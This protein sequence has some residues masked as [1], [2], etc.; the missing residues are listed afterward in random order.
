MHNSSDDIRVFLVVPKIIVEPAFEVRLA[1][2]PDVSLWTGFLYGP[3]GT[4]VA[5]VFI[6]ILPILDQLNAVVIVL[7]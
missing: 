7:L 5:P 6:S 2:G 3:E 1:N 4:I